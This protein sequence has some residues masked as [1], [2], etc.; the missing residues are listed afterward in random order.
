M[1]QSHVQLQCGHPYPSLTFSDG[2]KCLRQI[3]EGA[4]GLLLMSVVLLSAGFCTLVR[5]VIIPLRFTC[6]RG[7]GDAQSSVPVMTSPWLT[8]ISRCIATV[9]FASS[10]S[11]NANSKRARDG[12][13]A[14]QEVEGLCSDSERQLF[15]TSALPT[16]LYLDSLLPLGD[17]WHR[18]I[19]RKLRDWGPQW[20]WKPL[21]EKRHSS[22][23]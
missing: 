11:H 5:Y 23:F 13:T 7:Y 21:T 14:V 20:M 12:L 10:L 1:K 17:S 3:Y 2:T 4:L 16:L 8:A 15:V 22:S 6:W 18:A 9:W 19:R